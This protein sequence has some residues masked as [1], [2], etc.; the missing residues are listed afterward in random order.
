MEVSP[1]SSMDLNSADDQGSNNTPNSNENR[2][3]FLTLETI[4]I[5]LNTVF[6]L[7]NPMGR[8]ASWMF[9]SGAPPTDLLRNLMHAVAGHIVQ[10][11]SGMTSNQSSNP[12][13]MS[14]S[15]HTIG[16]TID[17]NGQNSGQSTQA[18]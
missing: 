18:R 10:D 4:F 3:E 14:H 16:V 13:N 11:P 17:G 15:Q 6:F 2:C 1:D 9:P 8:G 12:L 5:F 7:A